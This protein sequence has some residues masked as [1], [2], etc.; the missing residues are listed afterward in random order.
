MKN[1]LIKYVLVAIFSLL[2]LSISSNAPSL[3]ANTKVDIAN[4]YYWPPN[5]NAGKDLANEPLTGYGFTIFDTWN[6]NFNSSFISVA[7]SM[8][9]R[10]T[11]LRDATCN[12]LAKQYDWWI[13]RVLP[14]CSTPNDVSDCIEALSTVDES[15]TVTTYHESN[16]LPGNTFPADPSRGLG[17]GSTPS[18]WTT[19]GSD[20][21]QGMLV[22]VAGAS[23]GKANEK[24]FSLH[25]FSASVLAYTTYDLSKM[26]NFNP[27]TCLW[28]IQ[29]TC[30][31]QTDFHSAARISLTVHLPNSLTGWLAGRLKDPSISI[32]P[33]AGASS[34]NRIVVN[35]QPL[36]LPMVAGYAPVKQASPSIKKL[37]ADMSDQHGIVS[38]GFESRQDNS[39]EML[40]LF[41]KYLQNKATAMIPT[42]SFSK[43]YNFGNW[44]NAKCA[45][46][47]KG[48]YGLVTTNATA[49]LG[50][51]PNYKS[52]VLSYQIGAEHFTPT[53]DVLKGTYDLTLNSKVARCLYGYS[54]APVGATVS[55]T[56]D[57]GSEEVATT[58]LGESNGWLHLGAYNFTFSNPVIK[59]K[60]TQKAVGKK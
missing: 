26:R 23:G 5:F 36:L 16:L 24:Q 39:L 56:S 21:T 46:V 20:G 19:D 50:S 37:F 25:D 43:M 14:P 60:F 17:E 35:A 34:E 49:Y 59:V 1:V 47:T 6:T 53:G 31:I 32:S 11:S 30:G 13:M 15:G 29:S 48:L 8:N 27:V 52:G 58:V 38:L 33:V 3:A 54:A 55:I 45:F 9:T 18:L 40:S 41:S 57:K 51:P 2:T 42:W 44:G 22:T 28:R 10:C 7:D 4:P 12:E